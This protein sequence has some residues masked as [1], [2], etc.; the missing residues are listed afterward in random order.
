MIKWYK[1][2]GAYVC[3]GTHVY[4]LT[5]YYILLIALKVHQSIAPNLRLNVAQWTLHSLKWAARLYM[6]DLEHEVLQALATEIASAVSWKPKETWYQWSQKQVFF[7]CWSISSHFR[8]RKRKT[9]KLARGG[10]IYFSESWPHPLS[11]LPP[12]LWVKVVGLFF[13]TSGIVMRFSSNSFGDHGI[14]LWEFE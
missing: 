14:G 13:L 7:K 2:I 10:E 6:Q 3:I 8:S 12:T 5:D 1:N 4:S 11:F 9:E